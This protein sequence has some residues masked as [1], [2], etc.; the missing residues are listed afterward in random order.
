MSDYKN[1]KI[2]K[3]VSDETKYCYV[4]S[5]IFKLN[6]RLRTHVNAYNQW[7]KDSDK[8][9]YSSYKILKYT[10]YKI[11]LIENYPCEDKHELCLRESYWINNTE[12]TVN[13][14]KPQLSLE[15]KKATKKKYYNLNKEY[16]K[17]YTKKY[18]KQYLIENKDKLYSKFFC[19]CGGRYQLHNKGNHLKTNMHKKWLKKQQVTSESDES[20]SD[21]E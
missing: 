5:T 18:F 13:M 7:K 4:G 9:Y 12:N 20:E 6:K 1:A 14:I 10:D 2:Y 21:S 15:D 17:K 19:D 16:I 3:I 11:V 8:Y